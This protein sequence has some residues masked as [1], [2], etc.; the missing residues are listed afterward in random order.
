MSKAVFNTFPHRPNPSNGQRD[1]VVTIPPELQAEPY[2]GSMRSTDRTTIDALNNSPPP[3]ASRAP[4]MPGRC[5]EP[6]PS[7]AAQRCAALER[8]AHDVR[9]GRGHGGRGVQLHE[10]LRRC[11]A[12]VGVPR[13]VG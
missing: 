1:P 2:P 8:V 4:G 7:P 13:Q 6:S 5:V 12:A 3:P 11:A 10:R 9:N